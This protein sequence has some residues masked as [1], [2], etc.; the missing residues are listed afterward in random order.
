MA[1][2]MNMQ[3]VPAHAGGQQARREEFGMRRGAGQ[4]PAILDQGCHFPAPQPF[5]VYCQPA[6]FHRV[7][8]MPFALMST[9]YGSSRPLMREY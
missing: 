6:Q 1:N 8:G 5:R 4:G 9:A 7:N 2:H 3:N